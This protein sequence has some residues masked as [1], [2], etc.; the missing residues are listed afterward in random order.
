MALADFQTMVDGLV[1]SDSGDIAEADRDL[2]IARAVSRYS[3]DRPRPVVVDVTAPGGQIL[4]PPEGWDAEW[5][6]VTAAEWPVDTVPPA[7][8]GP[9]ATHPTPTGPRLHLPAAVPA[10]QTLRLTYTLAHQVDAETDTVPSRDRLAV[11]AWAAALLLD[12]LASA[13]AGH[14]SSMVQADSVDHSSRSRDYAARAR[15]LRSLYHDELGLD[16]NRRTAA[17]AT[18]DLDLADSRGRDR[19]FH[20]STDR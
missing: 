3:A 9:V 11:C 18:V 6:R 1:R 20:R 5:S 10:G 19:L 14:V 8:L 13:Y 2:A 12:Q 16:L 7:L 15:A 17:S 4:P